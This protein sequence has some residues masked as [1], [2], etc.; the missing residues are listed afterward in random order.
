M[1]AALRVPVVANGDIDSP[2]KA[3]AVLRHTGADALMV[4]RAAQGRPWIFREIA[5]FLE[6]GHLLAPPATLDVSAWLLEHLQ[7]HYGLYGELAGM[8]TARKHI[9]WAVRD[10]PGGEGFRQAMNVLDTCEAQVQAVDGFLSRLA[11]DHP[12]WPAGVNQPVADEAVTT[13]RPIP[14]AANDERLR[15]LA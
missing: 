8:R 5:H 7:D 2:A 4:G 12:L 1:K 14:S 15:Q 9:G 6:T 3:L 10:L 11:Q 13:T